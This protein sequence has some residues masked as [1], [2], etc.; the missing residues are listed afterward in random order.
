[1]GFGLDKIEPGLAEGGPPPIGGK[2][3][4]LD[5]VAQLIITEFGYEEV[6]HLRAIK[7]TVGGFPRPLIDLSSSNFAKIFDD[8]FGYK[9]DP[10]FDPYANSLNYMLGSYVIPYM[11]LVGYVGT[12]PFLIGYKTKRLI[13][14]LLGVESGQDA[15]IRTYL[16]EKANEVVKPYNHTVAEFT[17]RISGLRNKLAN[18][19]IKDEGIVVPKN[20]GA[21]NRSTANVLSA[22]LYSLS[23]SRTAGEILRVVYGTGNEHVGGGFFPKGGNGKIAQSYLGKH[24]SHV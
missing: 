22:D 4:N 5:G 7:S 2:K 6:D 12:N 19:G 14:G 20:L 17:E 18:C 9:L 16:F 3:A 10:P 15:V 8:A 23:Y 24:G 21:Q 11:G 1:M 13:A